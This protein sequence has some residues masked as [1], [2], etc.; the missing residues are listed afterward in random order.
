MNTFLEDLFSLRNKTA[1]VTGGAKGL[2]AMISAALAGAG[3]RVIVVS[4]SS[5][6]PSEIGPGL[7][8]DNCTCLTADLADMESLRKIAVEVAKLAPTLDILV[9]NAGAFSA[10]DIPSVDAERWDAEMALNL[11]APFFLVQQLLPQL[12]AAAKQ[13]DPARVINI[14]S[15]AAL[16]PKSTG[17]YAYGC[18]KAALH[19]LTR[20]LASDLTASGIHVNAIAPGFFPT[21][22]TAGLF[23]ANPGSREATMAMV[24]AGRFGAASDI[25]GMTIALCSRAGAYLSG[26]IIPVEGGLWSA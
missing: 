24:P 12:K 9:N 14:G 7:N 19:Q 16:W 13:G 1:L 17:A 10:S 25:G 8:G 20:T 18:S 3:A 11:R 2:G 6:K 22:M 5:A 4:R 21:D 26:A 15:I 23:E